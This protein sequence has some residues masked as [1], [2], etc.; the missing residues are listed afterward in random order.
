[1]G[2]RRF[3]VM[4]S[5]IQREDQ[6]PKSSYFKA[7]FG[8]LAKH[9]RALL[10]FFHDWEISKEFDPKGYAPFTSSKAIMQETGANYTDRARMAINAVI[11]RIM[12]EQNNKGMIYSAVLLH[13]LEAEYSD[14]LELATKSVQAITKNVTTILTQLGYYRVKI[15]GRN[16]NR[17]Y[18]NKDGIKRFS[19]IYSNDASKFESGIEMGSEEYYE[20]MEEYKAAYS[21]VDGLSESSEFDEYVK[22]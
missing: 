12:D 16:E 10:K 5:A 20:V 8:D 18:Y 17:V 13:Y 21:L 19:A 11:N 4:F 3:C 15:T 7:L 6:V 1:M 22:D 9:P 2:D 14:E